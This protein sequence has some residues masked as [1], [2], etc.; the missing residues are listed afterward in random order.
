MRSVHLLFT[1]SF[2]LDLARYAN[3]Q[4]GQAQTLDC[5]GS[6][7]TRATQPLAA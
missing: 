4:S 6:N 2:F 1:F 7:P 3:R 5:V